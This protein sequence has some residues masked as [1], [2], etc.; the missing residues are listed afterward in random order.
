MKPNILSLS[1]GMHPYIMIFTFLTGINFL[2]L[3]QCDIVYRNSRTCFWKV[4]VT[5]KI[6]EINFG[7]EGIVIYKTTNYSCT[8]TCNADKMYDTLFVML[9]K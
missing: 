8:L 6:R 7:C 3:N 1:K 5:K 4:P 2:S 9:T